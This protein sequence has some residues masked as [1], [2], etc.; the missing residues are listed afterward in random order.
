MI[1]T[2]A[3]TDA[4]HLA[5]DFFIARR[6][7]QYDDVISGA[8]ADTLDAIAEEL[9][10]CARV[11]RMLD[12]GDLDLLAEL[13]AWA[14]G[15]RRYVSEA[16]ESIERE[17]RDAAKARDGDPEYLFVGMTLEESLAESERAIASERRDIAGL[18]S[19]LA[20]IDAA[21]NRDEVTA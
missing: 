11:R 9:Q 18:E 4:E 1:A 7:S 6:I 21:G 20:R 8:D 17:V 2:H 10:R 15:M 19:L 12:A 13:A 14:S 16:Y 5:L 3:L